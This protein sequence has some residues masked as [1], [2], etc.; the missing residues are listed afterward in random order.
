MRLVIRIVFVFFL[1]GIISSCNDFKEA[2]VTGVKGFKIKKMNTEGIDADVILGV[3]NPNS[4]GFS[5]YPSEFDITF[6]GVNL[7][8]AKLKKRVHIDANCEKPYVFELKSTFKDINLL[9]LTKLL[10]G[11]KLGQMEVKGE[12]K[13][14]K[15]WLK[16]SFPVNHTEK[17]GFGQ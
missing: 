13:A 11:S 3:K 7:G 14:G 8:K 10:S 9:D 5:I 2:E 16:K 1:L 4:I 6:S 12:L 17:I 15:F